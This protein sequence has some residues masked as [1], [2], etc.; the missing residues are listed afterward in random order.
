MRRVLLGLT[1]AGL[2]LAPQATAA[3][4][5]RYGVAAGEMTATSAVLWA[6]S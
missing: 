4:G 6:R 1:V 5:F 3:P 2:A